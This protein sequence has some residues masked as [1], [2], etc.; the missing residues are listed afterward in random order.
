MI[1]LK[2][3]KYFADPWPHVVV[4]DII[5]DKTALDVLTNNP[6]LINYLRDISDLPLRGE[7][8]AKQIE[9]MQDF[10][11][12]IKDVLL[13]LDN[14][15]AVKNLLHK[16]F[17]PVMTEHYGMLTEEEIKDFTKYQFTYGGYPGTPEDYLGIPLKNTH[18]DGRHKY[19]TGMMY[20]R[21]PG[22]EDTGANFYLEKYDDEGNK[23]GE[24]KIEYKN[25]IAIFWPNLTTS[26][27]RA[28]SRNIVTSSTRRFI[29]FV[30]EGEKPLHDYHAKTQSNDY[31]G[32]KR[33][34]W[35]EVKK[36]T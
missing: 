21:E 18:I 28:E 17:I 6:Q 35:Q 14:S 25:N 19:Y 36:R 33:Y 23:I 16:H 13:K 29:N 20:F 5:S 34:G 4:T 15:T 32:T 8:N 2:K 31:D 12:V 3:A 30:A 10:P 9:D 26:W 7:L 24:K 22:D 11:Q 27:H 1:S